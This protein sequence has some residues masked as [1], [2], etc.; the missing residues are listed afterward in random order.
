MQQKPQA[1]LFLDW[2]RF[3]VP[4]STANNELLPPHE[5]FAHSGEVLTPFPNYAQAVALMAGR[6][7]WNDDRPEQRKLVTLTGD[8]LLR[9][10]RAG[11]TD[12]LL[13]RWID[14]FEDLNVPRLDIAIDTPN[15]GVTPEK[16]Y[17]AW[18]A[19]ELRTRARTVTRVQGTDEDGKGKGYTV[20]IGSRHSEQFLRVYD[21]RAE[22]KAKGKS[23]PDGLWTRVELELKGGKAV[24]ALR[25]IAEQGIGRAGPIIS[26]FL[27][28]PANA[29]WRAITSGDIV[30]SL[31]VGRKE[32]DTETW[33]RR[34]VFPNFTAALR[35]GNPRAQEIVRQWAKKVPQE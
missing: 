24:L 8:D 1:N 28:W 9:A 3:S 18:S 30:P 13:C 32:T 2:L 21:K 31:E 27:D 26:Q 6:I 34:V 14:A 33:L 35:A 19:Q 15:E 23:V 11:V 29:V 22:Q 16:L 25:F 4:I 10:R 20:Y 5:T 12:T 7:D 17:A